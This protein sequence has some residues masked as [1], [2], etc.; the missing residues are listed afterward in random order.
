MKIIL[1]L[2]PA[3][4][5]LA[6]YSLQAQAPVVSNVTY[7]Q[8]IDA[9]GNKTKLVDIQY[10]LEG[11]RSM[12]VE[13]FFSHDG[14]VTYPIACTTVIGDAGPGVLEGTGQN[15]KMATWDASVDWDQNFTD[16]GRIMIKATFGDQPTG[17]PGLD[18]NGTGT[19]PVD[20]NGTGPMD[21]NQSL[22]FETVAIPFPANGGVVGGPSQGLLERKQAAVARGIY[23]NLP[24][25]YH[26]D[27]Y[28]VTNEKWNE[29]V[30]WANDHGYSDLMPVD[31]IMMEGRENHA[32]SGAHDYQAVLKWLNARS[33]MEG[34]EPVFYVDINEELG[35]ENGD[36]VISNGPDTLYPSSEDYADPNF[37]DPYAQMN[38]SPDPNQ[39][40][41]WD[42]GEY[43]VDRDNNGIFEPK[44]WHDWN[45][46]GVLDQGLIMVYRVGQIE[47]A[48]Q[49]LWN[50]GYESWYIS[51]H[52][53]ETAN[54]Y[55]LPFGGTWGEFSEFYYFAMGGR[56]EQAAF[57][58]YSNENTYFQEW[59]WGGL[60][61]IN[62][63]PVANDFAHVNDP[64][65]IPVG[66]KM[67]N[68]FGLFDMIGNAAELSQDIS[69]DGYA[70]TTSLLIYSLGGS[71]IAPPNL[72][73]PGWGL[74]GIENWFFADSLPP[75]GFRSL[76]LEF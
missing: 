55:R 48:P 54:G 1:K 28:E 24:V 35:D 72:P 6:G 39:N 51:K 16:I 34:L 53:K 5:L 47:R 49:D 62:I 44:E 23:P 11:N 9:D 4:L 52:I 50:D 67:P 66:S 57:D 60:D 14:G 3:L 8:R 43:F 13:F 40:N 36:G 37:V 76:R 59:P 30:S 75:T 41:R 12:F 21:D 69:V 65:E 70:G 29:V 63:D 58:S 68:G 10:D 31:S 19:G 2:L 46:N 74:T 22:V 17:F 25:M 45:N 15:H 18:L 7:V 20:D 61:D 73:D 71:H 27:K 64:M 38:F 42:P 33:E 26:F 32:F 56:I